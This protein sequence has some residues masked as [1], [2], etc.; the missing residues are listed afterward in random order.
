MAQKG[1]VS[2]ALA[3]LVLVVL[4]LTT[5]LAL[6]YVQG[7]LMRYKKRWSTEK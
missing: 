3:I 1:F 4:S 6:E 2:V 5:L 7:D